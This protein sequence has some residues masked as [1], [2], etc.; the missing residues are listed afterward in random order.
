MELTIQVNA[1]TEGLEV[2]QALLLTLKKQ[3]TM[4]SIA[5]RKFI[6]LASRLEQYPKL[7]K[8]IQLRLDSAL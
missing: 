4:N 7:Q 5:S 3:A 8:A 6:L 1:L 2:R